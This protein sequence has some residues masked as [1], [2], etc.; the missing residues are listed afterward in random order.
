MS[1]YNR[2]LTSQAILDAS[3]ALDH[4][5]GFRFQEAQDSMQ[6]VLRYL[7]LLEEAQAEGA[8]P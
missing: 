6:A 3:A 7:R 5:R 1:A 2:Q 8:Q 4:L